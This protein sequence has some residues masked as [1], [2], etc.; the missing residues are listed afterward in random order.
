M[1]MG[2]GYQEQA[3]RWGDIFSSCSLDN[4]SKIPEENECHS[5]NEGF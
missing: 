1:G 4:H 5:M 3:Q 2:T